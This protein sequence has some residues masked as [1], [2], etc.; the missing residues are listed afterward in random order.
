MSF[1]IKKL[2]TYCTLSNHDLTVVKL[3]E[4][5]INLFSF[6]TSYK[7]PISAMIDCL[8]YQYCINFTHYLQK[9][10]SL[11]RMIARYL[12]LFSCLVG[13]ISGR[14]WHSSENEYECRN[15]RNDVTR[16]NSAWSQNRTNAL[17]KVRRTHPPDVCIPPP[18]KDRSVWASIWDSITGIF[19]SEQVSYSRVRL[20]VKLFN[21]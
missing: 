15:C 10:F 20:R 1:C 8:C 2:T 17:A 11:V 4:K 9:M 19:G 18:E 13:V 3:L 14:F 12:L 5:N 7:I 21:A 16:R 6:T